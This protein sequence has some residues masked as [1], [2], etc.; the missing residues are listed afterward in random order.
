[1][2]PKTKIELFGRFGSLYIWS[3]SERNDAA[4]GAL[5]LQDLKYV[6]LLM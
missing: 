3:I 4:A 2:I 5:L 1:M 6:L